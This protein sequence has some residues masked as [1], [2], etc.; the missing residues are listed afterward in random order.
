M[1][2]EPRRLNFHHF[3]DTTR[4]RAILHYLL[5]HGDLAGR[6]ASGGTLITLAVDDRLLGRLLTF[7]P[8]SEDLEDGG[9]VEPDDHE[10]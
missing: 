10:Q 1:L 5:E 2:A 3:R 7:N 8:G 6:D 4:N 9:D